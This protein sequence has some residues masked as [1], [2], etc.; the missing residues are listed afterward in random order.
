MARQEQVVDAGD[1][2]LARAKVFDAGLPWQGA[3]EDY[4]G[5]FYTIEVT[6]VEKDKALFEEPKEAP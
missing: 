1:E 4:P 3:E 2:D 6:E 5:G